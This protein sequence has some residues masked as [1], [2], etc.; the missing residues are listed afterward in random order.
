MG[1]EDDIVVASQPSDAREV[2]EE[3]ITLSLMEYVT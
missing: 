1:E 2:K 3:K